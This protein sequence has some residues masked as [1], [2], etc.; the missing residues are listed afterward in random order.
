MVEKLTEMRKGLERRRDDLIRE[1]EQGR[2][3]WQG[4]EE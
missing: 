4:L 2:G 1:E 3:V